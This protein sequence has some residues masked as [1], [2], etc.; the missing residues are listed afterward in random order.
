MSFYF[1]FEWIERFCFYLKLLTMDFAKGF[2]NTYHTY[3]RY[4]MGR[5]AV[6]QWLCMNAENCGHQISPPQQLPPPQ[7]TSKSGI[8]KARAKAK[9]KVNAKINTAARPIEPSISITQ[10]LALANAIANSSEPRVQVPSWVIHLLSDM[11]DLRKIC[12]KAYACSDTTNGE[13]SEAENDARGK[14][15]ILE[16]VLQVLERT[17]END[18]EGSLTDC[19]S[20][21][22]IFREELFSK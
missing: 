11:I 7:P 16:E 21:A 9:A 12:T 10:Y 13:T 19:S 18:H 4:C 20:G 22:Q 5:N 15:R 2:L 14:I 3:K 8:K 1:T 17:K 6:V